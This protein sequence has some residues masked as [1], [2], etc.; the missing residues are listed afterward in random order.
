MTSRSRHPSASSRQSG[1]SLIIVLMI[2]LVI[3]VLGVGGAQLTLQ[4]ER[5]TRADRDVEIAHQAAEQALTDAELDITK[6]RTNFFKRDNDVGFVK[7]CS[8]AADSKG[9]CKPSDAGVLP[10]WATAFDDDSKTVA[11][12]TFTNQLHDYFGHGIQSAREPR[13]IIE[14]TQD[15]DS[16]AADGS[17]DLQS[18]TLQFTCKVL[19]VTAMGYGPNQDT[20]VVLQTEFRY[21]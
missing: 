3:T 15:S 5:G 14:S 21:E 11:Y 16:C 8:A 12:G 10:V 6:F 9:L 18:A 20:K 2:L 17:A 7:G 13:Y 19:R 1:V 4:A